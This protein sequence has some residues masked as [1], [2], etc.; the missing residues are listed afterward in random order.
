MNGGLISSRDNPN[1][2][3]SDLT[4]CSI[5]LPYEEGDD[6]HEGEDIL[7][8]NEDRGNCL[9]EDQASF[10]ARLFPDK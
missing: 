8:P 4:R 3:R 10:R 9:H 6:C 1:A 7:L 5:L 2:E